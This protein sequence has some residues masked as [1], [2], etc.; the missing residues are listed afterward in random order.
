MKHFLPLI[1]TLATGCSTQFNPAPRGPQKDLATTPT[2][3][4]VGDNQMG[5]NNTEFS[6]A[7]YALRLLHTGQTLL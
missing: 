6:G 1:L 4:F 5:I 2:V 3:L 7:S